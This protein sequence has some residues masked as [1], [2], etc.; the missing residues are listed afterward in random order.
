MSLGFAEVDWPPLMNGLDEA[1][2]SAVL[3][4]VY[5]HSLPS[6]I[7]TATVQSCIEHFQ[8][9]AELAHFVDLCRQFVNNSSLRTELQ[10]LVKSIHASL[11][12][13]VGLFEIN[14]QMDMPVNTSRLWQS[15]KLSLGFDHLSV[16]LCRLH[17]DKLRSFGL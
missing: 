13:M 14:D 16:A 6:T 3:H 7:N 12:R 11:E 1:V 17:D 8:S 10:S 15:L 4:Y 5:S 2:L 9:R